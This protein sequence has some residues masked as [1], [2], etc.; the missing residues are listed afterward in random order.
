MADVTQKVPSLRLLHYLLSN[1]EGE[2]VAHCLD[3]DLVATGKDGSEAVRRLNRLVQFQI[4]Q[5]F[6]DGNY[7]NLM[8][9]APQEYW[10]QFMSGETGGFDKLSLD[11]EGPPLLPFPKAHVGVLATQC[12]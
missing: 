10:D 5:V 11:V 1:S 2:A 8:T 6:K 12:A 7:D 4:G 9:P 3:L